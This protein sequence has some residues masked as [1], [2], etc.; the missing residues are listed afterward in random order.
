[1]LKFMARLDQNEFFLT[2]D[3]DVELAGESDAPCLDFWPYVDG[4]DEEA[5]DGVAHQFSV[6]YFF[7]NSV[8]GLE[9]VMIRTDCPHT[10]LTV[11]IDTNEQKI[12]GHHVFYLNSDLPVRIL[13]LYPE[14]D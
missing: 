14:L 13:Q 11:V 10:H 8:R 6:D 3:D 4:L 12:V 9:H 2:M 5:I 7:K 1:M